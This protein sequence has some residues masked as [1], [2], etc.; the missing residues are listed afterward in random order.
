MKNFLIE[1]FLLFSF[2]PTTIC[3]ACP[4]DSKTK[5]TSS[6]RGGVSSS[7]I[8]NR[9]TRPLTLANPVWTAPRSVEVSGYNPDCQPWVS[10]DGKK[11]FFISFDDLNG[12]SRP[13]YQGNWDIYIAEWDSLN[14]HWGTPVNAGTNINT[15]GPERRPCVS[16]DG[17][18]LF[19][20]SFRPGG[21]GG[22]DI[23]VSIWNG[24]GWGSAINLG[25]PVN[26][27]WNEAD[28]AISYDGRRLY[29]A[30]NRPGGF[31][32]DDIWVAR[33]NGLGWD[34]V[35]NAG[36]GVNTSG[37]ESRPFETADRTKLYFSDFGGAPR[38]GSFG[39]ADLWVSTWT[40]SVWGPAA[41]VGPPIN[42]DLIVC[43]P[44]VSPD[45][46]KLYVASESYE[47]AYGDEDIWKADLLPLTADN[48]PRPDPL[49]GNT[50]V[51][52]DL[53][54]SGRQNKSQPVSA[55]RP[56]SP[57][58]GNEK[59]ILN[60]IGV[61][62]KGATGWQNTG[63]L[64]GAMYVHA[65]VESPDSA[66]YA[67][68]Y[69]YGDVFKTTD[70]GTNWVNTT[71]LPGAIHVYSLLVASDSTLYAGTYPNGDVFKS[72]DGGTT[73]TNTADLVGATAVRALLETADHRLLAGAYAGTGVIFSSTDQGNSWNILT[74]I[75][76]IGNGIFCLYQ[77]RDSALYAGGW[78]FPAKSTNGGATWTVLSNMPF[79]QEMRSI[80]SITQTSDGTIYATGWIHGH[81]GYVFKT[82]D[83]GATWDTT[84]R[85]MIGSV[86]SVRV[87]D[88]LEARDGSLYIGFQPA[89]DSVCFRS[90]DAGATWQNTGVLTDAYNVLTLLQAKDGS[91]YAGTTPNGDLFKY[92][93]PLMAGDVTRDGIV[94]LVDIVALI[95]YVF[96]ATNPPDPLW[97]GDVNADCIIDLIDI[98]YL[99]QFVFYAGS[100][101]QNGC[102]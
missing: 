102:A 73:W 63:E 42:T 97:L 7:P 14:H 84:G 99:I 50:S 54:A 10:A 58:A 47:G 65:L 86:H 53:I 92:T 72:S 70:Q 75:P 32:G 25:F 77:A 30:V 74:T 61:P 56:V 94:D 98:V 100:A 96:F 37:N 43:T 69:P 91:I 48:A 33:W 83:G 35:T 76:W 93:F 44:F 89:K 49:E 45:G 39:G 51:F 82:T 16:T 13:G 17:T 64:S 88:L 46:N 80:N 59:N 68:T 57:P 22:S 34:S 8:T 81:G 38:A 19:F 101:P 71:D 21:M 90:T 29:F 11:L 6:A 18:K 1:L 55:T 79:P 28:P 4:P 78:G 3:F 52:N 9:N 62:L 67:G 15:P 41:N 87:Y 40:G 2:F 23:Y 5:T 24:T 27:P 66:I 60:Q 95:N 36:A 12:P 26:G 20:S 85:I 31:G